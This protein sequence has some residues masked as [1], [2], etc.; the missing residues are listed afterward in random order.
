VAGADL[1]IAAT[2]RMLLTFEDLHPLFAGRPSR[3]HALLV[4]PDAAG[5]VPAGVL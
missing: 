5:R 2:S 1:Q 3:D 4:F